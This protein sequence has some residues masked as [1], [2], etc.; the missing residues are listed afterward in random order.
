MIK[1]KTRSRSSASSFKAPQRRGKSSA[2]PGAGCRAASA[3]G[4]AALLLL[5]LH[6]AQADSYAYTG[7]GAGTAAT[8]ITGSFNLGFNDT[9]TSTTGVTPA[10]NAATALTFAGAA[11]NNYTATDNLAASPFLFNV[12]TFTNAGNITVAQGTGTTLTSGAATTINLNNAGTLAFNL[13]L[14]NGGFLTTFN[15]AGNATFGGVISGTGGLTQAGTGTLTLS[16]I[17]TYTGGTTV[18]AGT[19]TLNN[20]GGAGAVRGALTVN[21]GAT[22]TL[23]VNNALGYTAGTQVTTL[24]VNGGTVNV[25]GN[26][27]DEGYI[28][29]FN[30]TGGTMAYASGAY[31]IA[32]GDATAPGIT[33]NASAT[34][35]QITGGVN[36][37]S[38]NLSYNVAKGATASGIDLLDSGVVSGGFGVT[39]SGIGVLAF[40]GTNTYTGGTTVSGGTLQVGD[41][42]T[43]GTISGATGA[44]TLGGGTLN[45]KGNATAADSQTVASLAL[46]AGTNSRIVFAPGAGQTD[47]LNITSGTLTTGA[48]SA[49]NV[50][51]SLGTTNGATVGNDIVTFGTAPALTNGILGGAYTVTDTGGTGFATLNG[52]KQVVRL[53]DTGGTN[54]LPVSGGAATGNYFVNQS[55]S[56]TSTTTPGSLVEA[57]SGNVTANTVT[58]DTTGLASGANLSLGGN[59][60]TLASGIIFNGANPYTISSTGATGITG[61]GSIIAAGTGTLNFNG[62]VTLT[63]GS[64]IPAPTLL[65][66]ANNTVNLNGTGTS[67]SGQHQHGCRRQ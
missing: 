1:Q 42:T 44:L 12:L 25:N 49:L 7:G 36:I 52:S 20:G 28:T 9:T 8:P 21:S 62:N 5:G 39:K 38:G 26:Q 34:T 66:N 6:S 47:T 29:A 57:L 54:G 56:T 61:A 63:G 37:R 14:A 11:G 51:Y 33:S 31:Q 35:S 15:G 67:R 50:N 58:V 27:G 30:L 40:T 43:N 46:T 16:A 2:F 55:Y 65:L 24:F 13:A 64:T 17:N 60:L 48:G 45:I 4:A 3:L 19:L 53:T 23:N 18:N 22:L 59:S 10:S 41:G 32:A